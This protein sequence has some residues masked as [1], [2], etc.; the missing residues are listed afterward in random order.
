MSAGIRAILANNNRSQQF[1]QKLTKGLHDQYVRVI[2]DPNATLADLRKIKPVN[3]SEQRN[4]QYVRDV[5]KAVT[6]KEQ[7]RVMISIANTVF[8]E[9]KFTPLC[10]RKNFGSRKGLNYS[11]PISE[12]DYYEKTLWIRVTDP[13]VK[14][15]YYRSGLPLKKRGTSKTVP[16]AQHHSVRD[17]SS[18]ATEIILNNHEGP[19]VGTILYP[20]FEVQLNGPHP[21]P[22]ARL[23][24]VGMSE[25]WNYA[26]QLGIRVEWQE[27]DGTYKY[28]Y[29]QSYQ[30]LTFASSNDRGAVMQYATASAILRYI[31]QTRMHDPKAWY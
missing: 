20:V 16:L 6:K 3:A 1:V 8:Q 15:S 10:R 28:V 19:P 26:N 12:L 22:W 2:D 23:N 29:Q 9:L 18:S 27:P 7:A 17:G 25:D 31:I 21:L 30:G 13:G 5:I 4:G 11:T 14:E 24:D